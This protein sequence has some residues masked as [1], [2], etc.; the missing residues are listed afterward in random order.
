MSIHAEGV[1]KGVNGHFLDL[2]DLR[3]KIGVKDVNF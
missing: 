1:V 3:R 2:P